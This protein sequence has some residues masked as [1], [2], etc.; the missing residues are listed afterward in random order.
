MKWAPHFRQRKALL[1]H[2]AQVSYLSRH[3]W[4]I[5]TDRWSARCAA[6]TH[7]S[8]KPALPPSCFPIFTSSD[9]DVAIW[10]PYRVSLYSL[11]WIHSQENKKGPEVSVCSGWRVPNHIWEWKK[12]A[13]MLTHEIISVK[14][15]I[16][17]ETPYH[18]VDHPRAVFLKLFHTKDHWT[19]K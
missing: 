6:E 17:P 4:A 16:W 15:K 12:K 19:H 8:L 13:V 5:L 10:T 3:W 11:E 18:P 1:L 14:G 7:I 9:P 2:F